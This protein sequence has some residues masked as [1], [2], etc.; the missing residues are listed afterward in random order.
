MYCMPYHCCPKFI[1]YLF[2]AMY[3]FWVQCERKYGEDVMTARER[4]LYE[5]DR[6]AHRKFLNTDK[7]NCFEYLFL[8]KFM[9]QLIVKYLSNSCHIFF[10]SIP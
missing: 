3:S 10:G 5:K 8:V 6:G 9:Y 2:L 4:L 7:D 1:I